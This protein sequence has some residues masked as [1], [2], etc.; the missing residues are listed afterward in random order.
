MTASLAG[1]K[2]CFWTLH[3]TWKVSSPPLSIWSLSFLQCDIIR[4]EYYIK[5]NLWRWLFFQEW[6][7]E[8][9]LL[10]HGHNYGDGIWSIQLWSFKF[11]CGQISYICAC[12]TKMILNNVRERTWMM[13]AF[14]PKHH[15]IMY[16]SLKILF[17]ID[18]I[19][20]NNEM[21]FGQIGGA[22]KS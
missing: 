5:I 4:F 17:C 11:E 2:T 18:R 10:Q 15:L 7:Y 22:G 21:T 14:T 9:M 12:N 19:I 1:I 20:S 13:F 6:Y 3:I 8:T 16:V